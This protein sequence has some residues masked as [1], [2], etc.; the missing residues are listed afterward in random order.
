MAN[1]HTC[2]NQCKSFKVAYNTHAGGMFLNGLKRCNTC[3]VYFLAIYC[4]LIGKKLGCPCCRN[5]V[6]HSPRHKNRSPAWNSNKNLK[7]Y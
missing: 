1:D 7:R 5:Y 4:I 3:N 6:R 2:C